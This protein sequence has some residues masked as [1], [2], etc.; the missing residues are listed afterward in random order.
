MGT[1]LPTEFHPG[2]EFSVV[3]LGSGSP[4][5]DP[6]RSGP[7][8]LIQNHGQYLLVDMGNGTQARLYELGVSMRD[9]AAI[10]LTHHHLDHNEEFLPV[11]IYRLLRGRDVDVIG[12]PGTETLVNFA[13]DFYAEDMAYRLS[14]RGRPLADAGAPLVR[15]VRGGESFD[16]A[17]MKVTTA[18]VNH[19]IHTVAYRF[20]VGGQSIVISGDTTYSDSLIQLA[21]NADVLVLDSGAAIVRRGAHRPPGGQG[22]HDEAHPSFQDVC[23]TAERSGVKKLVLTHLAPGEVDE[24]ET[25]KAIGER[26]HG[27]VLIAHDLLEVVPGRP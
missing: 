1:D 9:L 6:K 13:C 14:R 4:Q 15:E 5:F 11:L 20:D 16:L 19:T 8:A 12:P 10:L 3:I 24:A 22:E 27:Q 26:Y 17:G 18:K 2:G 21:H 25:I 23:T 7:A